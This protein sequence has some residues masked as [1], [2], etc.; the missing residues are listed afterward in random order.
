M[1]TA[2]VAQSTHQFDQAKADLFAEGLLDALNKSALS[3]MISLGHRLGLFDVMAE[4]P[5]CSSV[6]LAKASGLNERYLREWLA[7]MVSGGVISYEAEHKTYLLPQEHAAFLTRASAPDNIAVYAQYIPMMGQVE[8]KLMACF[9]AGGGLSYDDYPRFHTVMAEDSAQTVLPAL[10]DTILPLIPQMMQRLEEGIRVLDIGCGS[11]RALVKM[12][13]RFPNS[14]F[15]GYDLCEVA[16]EQ[17]RKEAKGL[18]LNNLHLEQRDLTGFDDESGFDL[19][20]AFD[21]IHDQKDPQGVLN[22]IAR[23]LRPG[24][25]FLMQD[26]SGS[27]YLE[28]NNDHPIAP[29]LYALSTSHC[30]SVSLGQGGAGL[31][32]MWGEEVAC[33]MLERAGFLSINK[34][35]LAHDFQN[36]YFVAQ[37]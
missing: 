14:R 20:T 28:K 15:F 31:G 4:L 29:L 18:G 1:D 11:A 34:R 21:A 37:C 19:I 3:V 13:K 5:A 23:S 12:A 22:G 25:T 27:S 24:G 17:G 9:K 16:L 32:T 7:V 30:M 26:I 10:F 2:Q 35:K 36:V 6:Q 33:D 8:D